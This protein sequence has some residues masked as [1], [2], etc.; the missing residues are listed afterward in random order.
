MGGMGGIIRDSGVLRY[1]TLMK[2]A[3]KAVAK[4]AV[5]RK[6]AA[7]KKKAGVARKAVVRENAGLL[8]EVHNLGPVARAD[9]RLKPLTVFAG[10]NGTGKTFVCKAI[11]SAIG[12]M[13]TN[14]GEELF[15]RHAKHIR[16]CANML[17]QE[18][19]MSVQHARRFATENS[20]NAENAEM[21]ASNF[22]AELEDRLDSINMRASSMFFEDEL[23]EQNIADLREE[24]GNLL[25]FYRKN[26]RVLVNVAQSTPALEHRTSRRFA[27]KLHPHDIRTGRRTPDFRIDKK[28]LRQIFISD[29]AKR[30]W[31]A[32]SELTQVEWDDKMLTIGEG[33]GSAFY[34]GVAANFQIAPQDVLGALK[35]AAQVNISGVNFTLMPEVGMIEFSRD[36]VHAAQKWSRTL[37]LDSPIYWKLKD[38]LESMRL[39]SVRRRESYGV[40]QYFYDL[41]VLLRKGIIDSN[42]PEMCRELEDVIGGKIVMTDTN[43]LR[44]QDGRGD[45]SMHATAGGI[46]NLG[47]L[48][49]LIE[50]GVVAKNAIVFIDE[51]EINLHPEWQVKMAEVLY[52]LARKGVNIVLATHSID[53]LKRLE[54]YAKEDADAK[55][56]MA[57]NHFALTDKGAVVK[58]DGKSLESKIS[59][60]MKEL[61]SPFFDLYV[62]G[63]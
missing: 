38:A 39:S 12:A 11:H 21:R 35:N 61:S 29:Y 58:D 23:G 30:L 16:S 5:A 8:V 50:H 15:R 26:R 49:L 25:S 14:P 34:N 53:I 20:R 19:P 57:V 1:N 51:P 59:A 27:G 63:L 10:P 55:K 56:L 43:K 6:K 37:F 42:F 54:I 41:A 52:E 3:K 45:Y 28:S 24:C 9:L 47:I 17:K 4:A 13:I 36:S 40:P 44:F 60:V 18:M 22:F 48:S 32:I 46:V 7:A 2:S 33:G 62:R 31:Q